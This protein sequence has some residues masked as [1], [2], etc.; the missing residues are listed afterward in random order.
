MHDLVILVFAHSQWG[1]G[2]WKLKNRQTRHRV[3]HGGLHWPGHVWS[4]GSAMQGGS[5]WFMSGLQGEENS[6][7][8][9]SSW[10]GGGGALV[11]ASGGSFGGLIWV[12]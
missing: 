3:L 1:E 4:A 12:E 2:W 10:R 8:E 9:K 5:W 11:G 6:G 7:R